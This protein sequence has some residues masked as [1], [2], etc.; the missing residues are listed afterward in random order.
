MVDNTGPDSSCTCS[1]R[2]A[3]FLWRP[4]IVFLAT[5]AAAFYLSRTITDWDFYGHLRFGLD[6]LEQG[7]LPQRDPYS[8]VTA[9]QG[10]INHEWLSEV[11][12]ASLYKLLGPASLV[13]L[14]TIICLGIGWISY[15]YLIGSGLSGKRALI[16]LC[17]LLAAG[18]S[19]IPFVRPQLFTY[20]M[21]LL[22]LL[23]I[24][25]ADAGNYQCLWLAMP[26]MLLWA[27]LHGGYLAGIAV[28]LLWAI[29]AFFFKQG[30]I[31]KVALPA[32][33]AVLITLVNPYGL[34]LPIFLLRTATIS[35]P[36]IT[37]WQSINF[38]EIHGLIYLILLAASYL[39][40][41]F[42]GHSR[43]RPLF[44][45]LAALA[46]YSLTAVRH[47]PLFGLAMIVIAAP[48]FGVIWTNPDKLRRLPKAAALV[49]IFISLA[50]LVPIWRNLNC[51]A[52]SAD[53][54]VFPAKAVGL[55]KASGASGNLATEFNWG[56]YVIW[57]LGPDVK[58]SIDGRRETVYPTSAYRMSL[59]YMYG[60]GDWDKLL[61]DYK[62]DMALIQTNKPTY[63]LMMLLP[64]WS[65]VYK[66]SVSALFV[67]SKSP[68][69]PALRNAV[70]EPIDQGCFKCK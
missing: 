7:S 50:L 48:H 5:I 19:F 42:A 57:H 1:S 69:F 33:S 28:I 61:T 45:L 8:Y 66:D 67:P 63:N 15:L 60:T 34:K 36:E 55:I 2:S 25:K 56:E 9:G 22:L 6:I 30:A 51:I 58:V 23:I 4:A 18:A 13:G 12:F 35:R 3:P 40:Y 17:A 10:W 16:G 20:L 26:I 52:T 64:D 41:H 14:K 29:L 24:K 47:L 59:Q 21:F 49:P 32:I 39:G 31:W 43:S 68:S 11:S 65:L 44:L 62:S 70:P 46:L 53:E 37:E 54:L 27:N 38:T